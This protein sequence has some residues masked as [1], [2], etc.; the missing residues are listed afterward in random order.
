MF[1]ENLDIFFNSAMLADDHFYN[2]SPITGVISDDEMQEMEDGRT[3]LRALV[4]HCKLAAIG[5]L[6]IPGEYVELDGETYTVAGAKHNAG[7]A[8]LI[9]NRRVS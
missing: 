8:E 1:A 7:A 9:L 4:F 2:G 5:S 6:P 3:V